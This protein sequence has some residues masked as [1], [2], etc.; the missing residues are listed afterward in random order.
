MVVGLVAACFGIMVQFILEGRKQGKKK[1][2]RQ[3]ISGQRNLLRMKLR[4]LVRCFQMTKKSREKLYDKTV[5]VE[6]ETL[7][8]SF[9][10]YCFLFRKQEKTY[11][12]IAIGG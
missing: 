3:S 2:Q 1:L 9:E 7:I 4:Q 5:L 12:E 6:G 8:S 11:Q 10:K